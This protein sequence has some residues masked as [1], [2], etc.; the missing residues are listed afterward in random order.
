MSNE[1][2]RGG[3]REGELGLLLAQVPTR[4]VFGQQ[5]Q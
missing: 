5:Q 2:G 3:E 1:E 4:L